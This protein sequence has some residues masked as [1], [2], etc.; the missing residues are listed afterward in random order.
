M[1][2]DN[3]CL[4]NLNKEICK[5]RKKIKRIYCKKFSYSLLFFAVLKSF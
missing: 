2:R 3:Q 4:E 1:H 5:N